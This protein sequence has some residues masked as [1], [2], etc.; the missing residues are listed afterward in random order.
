MSNLILTIIH[1]YDYPFV[2]PFFKSLKEIGFKG[3]LVIFTSETVSKATKKALIKNGATLIDYNSAWPYKAEYAEAFKNILPD[4]AISNYRF[5]LYRQFLLENPGKYK[6][7]M[8]TDVRDVIFQKDPFK[9]LSEGKINFFLEDPIQTFRYSEL[10]YQWCSAANGTELTDRIIDNI[11]SCAGFT[12]GEINPI[13]EYLQ[14]IQKKLEFRDELPWAFDQGIHNGYVYDVK[15]AEMQVFTNDDPFV[16]TL[17]AY[18]PYKLNEKNEV[19]N[20]KDEVYAVVHQ[21]DRSGKL[22]AIVKERYI[23][24]RLKQKINRLYYSL[25]P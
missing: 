21:Y 17:G 10:N 12:I 3:D 14:H 2:E 25:M 5:V 22:F 20:S 15:P 6:N 18:Q 23:G 13:M 7:I 8:L 19:V 1:S 24:S 11:V 16:V 4:A 9:E